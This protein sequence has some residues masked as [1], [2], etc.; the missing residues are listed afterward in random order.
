MSDASNAFN[1]LNRHVSLHNLHFICPPLAV[2]L[3]NVYR[4]ASSLFIDGECLLSE[5]GTTQGDPL[6][7]VMY[8]FST[9]PLIRKLDGLATQVWL[10]DDAAAA[11]SLAALLVWWKQLSGLGPG[12]G[13]YVN[14]SKSW[15]A[16]KDNYYDT[17]CTLFAGT[18]LRFTTEP[19]WEL[20]L[21]PL[22][23]NPSFFRKRYVNGGMTLFSFPIL[24]PV[25]H[26]LH[27]PL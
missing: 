4:E 5:E 7:M 21:V 18:S 17:A 8:A 24:P 16:V 15:L 22:N 26:M 14:A 2:T 19:T 20:L 23:L 11:G 6:A 27:I 10:A 13:Y 9:V 12:Y 1:S 25:S 3:T